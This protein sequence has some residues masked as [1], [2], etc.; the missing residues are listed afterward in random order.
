MPLVDRSTQTLPSNEVLNYSYNV[1]GTLSSLASNLAGTTPYVSQIHYNASGQVTDQLLGN[2]LIQQSCYNPN[3]LRLSNIRAY[4]GALQS[5]ISSPASPQLNLSYTYESNGNVSQISDITRNQTLSYSY[6]ELDRLVSGGSADNRKYTYSP[7]GN[8]TSQDTALPNPGTSNLVSWWSMNEA[9]GTRFDNH[10]SNHVSD[11]NTISSISGK[12][13]KAAQ[14]V[15][16]KSQALRIPDNPNLSMG[17]GARMTACTWTK[18]DGKDPSLVQEFLAK[19]NAAGT[20]EYF[21][22]YDGRID[23]FAFL[24]TPR[25]NF[26]SIDGIATMSKPSVNVLRRNRLQSLFEGVDQ[27]WQG[28]GLETPQDGLDLRPGQFNRVEVRRIR[29]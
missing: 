2:S 29:W 25:A 13:G 14:F 4:A 21:L 24:V 5:C 1:M 9:D 11:N 3:T 8:I 23:R 6:D 7:T 12:Q 17:T 27:I 15:L 16:A 22:R 10:A 20:W 26:R 28:S 19:G 18:L